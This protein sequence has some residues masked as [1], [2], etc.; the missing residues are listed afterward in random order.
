MKELEILENPEKYGYVQISNSNLIKKNS[1]A[2]YGTSLRSIYTCNY[3]FIPNNGYFK[4]GIAIT[5]SLN[6]DIPKGLLND[7]EKYI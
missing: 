2:I 1:I 7:I 6:K 5:F 3:V 4:E